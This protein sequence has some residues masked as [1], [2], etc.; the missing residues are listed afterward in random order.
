MS[1][2]EI[3]TEYE[4]A[5]LSMAVS[6]MMDDIGKQL[7]E[8]AK[9]AENIIP[10]AE[11][12]SKFEKAL[13]KSYRKGKISSLKKSVSKASRYFLTACAAAIIVVAVS[14]VSVDAFRIK[15]IEWLA[16]IG[17]G[18]NTV[19]FTDQSHNDTILPENIPDKYIL[20]SYTN[21]DNMI[22]Y[23]YTSSDKTNIYISR[24]IK[25]TTF[26]IDNEDL[27]NYKEIVENG[28]A[29]YY[30]NKNNSSYLIWN[31]EDYSYIFFTD[32]YTISEKE[33]IKIAQT[34]E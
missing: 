12:R 1:D 4:N 24:Y 3:R 20:N 14:V 33:I 13:D 28:Q 9:S 27:E 22:K 31:T 7:I 17:G 15:F 10:S 23:Q 26:N 19:D 34:F 16:N 32:D 6:E 8:E 18:Y 30:T 25:N 11:A 5:V 2:K 29:F 21:N